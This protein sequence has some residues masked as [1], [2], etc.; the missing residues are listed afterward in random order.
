VVSQGN[1]A[2]TDSPAANKAS[3]QPGRGNAITRP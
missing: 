1:Q 3:S 2:L